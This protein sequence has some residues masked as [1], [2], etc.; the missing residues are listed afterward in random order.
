GAGGHAR[1]RHAPAHRVPRRNAPHPRGA[2]RVGRPRHPEEE[3]AG[4]RALGPRG[5]RRAGAGGAATPRR[6]PHAGSTGLAGPE[7]CA[8]SV[9]RRGG[10]VPRTHPGEGRDPGRGDPERRP[11]IRGRPRAGRGDGRPLQAGVGRSPGGVRSPPLTA[12]GSR[13]QKKMEDEMPEQQWDE[14]LLE[15]VRRTGEDLKR[16]GEEFLD[17]A[18]RTFDDL[19]DPAQQERLKARVAELRTWAK[20]KFEEARSRAE[21]ALGIERPKAA[22]TRSTKTRRPAARKGKGG[23]KTTRRAGGGGKGT[24]RRGR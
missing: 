1:R 4:S 5:R 8:R 18:Q 9:T 16:T 13:R 24:K 3:P 20:S 22:P 14:K 15:Y 19:R 11:R 6:V 23:S 7:D 12:P 2:R 10:N 17:Q 21:D